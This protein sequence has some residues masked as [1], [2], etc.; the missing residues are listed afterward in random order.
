VGRRGIQASGDIDHWK[1]FSSRPCLREGLQGF[2]YL[3]GSRACQASWIPEGR[4]PTLKYGE[5]QLNHQIP[6][7][8]LEERVRHT[9]Q[10]AFNGN[11]IVIFSDGATQDDATLL[12]EIPAIHA[13]GGFGSII[14]RNSFE[15][16]HN[17][18]VK[19]LQQI[20]NIYAGKTA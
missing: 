19:I 11:R 5:C 4:V 18:A 7:Y 2:H 20:I 15:R 8:T 17:Q 13:W 16:L 6:T 1:P 10:C 12:N 9:L 3:V 14:S